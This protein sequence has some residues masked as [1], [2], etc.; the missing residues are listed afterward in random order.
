MRHGIRWILAAMVLAAPAVALAELPPRPVGLTPAQF[1]ALRQVESQP[2]HQRVLEVHAT[3]KSERERN[4]D[5]T[6]ASDDFWSVVWHAGW[7]GTI[8]TFL[9]LGAPL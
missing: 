4:L 8:A 3:Y 5:F 9:I 1:Q 2:Q 6:R 7:P